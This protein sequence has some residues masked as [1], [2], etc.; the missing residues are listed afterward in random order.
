VYDSWYTKWDETKLAMVRKQF[1]CN[2]HG[3]KVVKEVQKQETG[4]ECGLYAVANATSIA[5][6][7]DPTKLVYNEARMRAHLVHCFSQK[8]LEPFPLVTQ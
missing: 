5:F 2:S 4:A 1:R 7:M 3:I 6:G 8:D